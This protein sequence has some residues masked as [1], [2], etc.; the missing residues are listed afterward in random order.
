[1]TVTA[2]AAAAVLLLPQG[3]NMTIVLNVDWAEPLDPNNPAGECQV[4]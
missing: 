3:G 1:M 4:W 2:A